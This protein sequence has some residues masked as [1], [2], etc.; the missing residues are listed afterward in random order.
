MHECGIGV[1]NRWSSRKKRVKYRREK[2]EQ[3][4]YRISGVSRRSRDKLGERERE[5]IL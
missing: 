3:V 1:G 2:K 4:E 5:K